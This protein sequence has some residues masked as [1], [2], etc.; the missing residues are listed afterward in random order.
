MKKNGE[1]MCF[2]D[3]RIGEK[4][5]SAKSGKPCLIPEAM[6]FYKAICSLSLGEAASHQTRLSALSIPFEVLSGNLVTSP[7]HT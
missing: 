3:E 1:N 2:T 6:P 7:I 4:K 5:K